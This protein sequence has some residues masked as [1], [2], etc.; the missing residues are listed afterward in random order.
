MGWP[1]TGGIRTAIVAASTNLSGEVLA[2]FVP[3]RLRG[4]HLWAG[5][6]RLCPPRKGGRK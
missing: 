5:V 4:R 1:R 3:S 2:A 6:L